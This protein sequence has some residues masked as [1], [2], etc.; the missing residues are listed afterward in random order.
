MPIKKPIMLDK[1]LSYIAENKLIT[2]KHK[3][4]LAVSGGID[5]VVMT[6][7]FHKAKFNIHL[8][9]CNFKLRSKESDEDERF[10]LN[11]AKKFKIKSYTK[12][13]ETLDYSDKNNLSVQMAARELRYEWFHELVEKFNYD[14]IAIAH[15]QD[16]LVETFLINLSR[17]TG[18]KGLTGMKAKQNK[19]IRPLLFASRKE[20]E[21]YSKIYKIKYREDSS[22]KE[23]K[24]QRNLIRHEIIPL[25]EKLNPSF[26]KTLIKEMAVLNSTAKVYEQELQK[27]LKAV[28]IS[29]KPNHV[30]S[31]Q[32]ILSLRLG[33]E[34]LYDL[35]NHYSFS[36]SV[37][38]D[39][40][41]SLCGGSG[42]L[43]YSENYVLLKDRK[44]LV[45][46]KLK[47]SE[48]KESI[49]IEEGDTRIEYPLKLNFSKGIKQKEFEISTSRKI[50]S[51]DLDLINYPLKIR[52]WKKGDYF[53]PL[54]MKNKKKLSDFFT[55]RK[56]NR[57]EK[58]KVWVLTS[59][60]D[61]VWII[62]HQIDERY[63]VRPETENLLNISLNE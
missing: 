50:I 31:V 62:G 38:R 3:V 11:M 46:E 25:F 18:I 51:V 30:L 24:Y 54:G 17:G 14:C 57:L 6:H 60:N 34:I 45:I 36:F 13:F 44:T 32:K 37:I 49:D 7:L 21:E 22:N 10:V 19:I 47:K 39:I 40:H 61:I 43:F 4:L 27:I 56:I 8:A 33:P 15:N 59:K 41:S 55:D 5:S 52:K 2:N 23:I 1:F 35:L 20:I 53:Y 28:T 26:K 48:S 12:N 63:K 9:H 42:K 58:E 29:E 16:D